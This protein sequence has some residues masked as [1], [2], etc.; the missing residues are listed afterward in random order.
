MHERGL[1]VDVKGNAAALAWMHEHA[2]EYGITF[3]VKNDPVHAQMSYPPQATTVHVFDAT[4]S[5][6]TTQI[7]QSAAVALPGGGLP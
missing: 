7:G 2:S 1:A 6:V 5:G 4:G 3:P